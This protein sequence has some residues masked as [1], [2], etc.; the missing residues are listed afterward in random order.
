MKNNNTIIVTFE[1]MTK[2]RTLNTLKDFANSAMVDSARF[3]AYRDTYGIAT[4]EPQFYTTME[5]M[6]MIELHD[7]S[8][9]V[10]YYLRNSLTITAKLERLH[11]SQQ[12]DTIT[13][14]AVDLPALF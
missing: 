6:T 10:T 11:T 2:A 14:V 7:G 5:R 13:L 9:E 3:T 1:G 8:Y 12:F 4:Y